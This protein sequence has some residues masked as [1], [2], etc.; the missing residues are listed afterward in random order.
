MYY[1]TRGTNGTGGWIFTPIEG[2]PSM[3]EYQWV[4][5]VELSIPGWIPKTLVDNGIIQGLFE[6]VKSLRTKL[7]YTVDRLDIQ[8]DT[9]AEA[10]A[11]SLE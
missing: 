4:L 1:N 9:G 7:S 5:E 6:T 8:I 11:A 10:S 3:T 2:Q